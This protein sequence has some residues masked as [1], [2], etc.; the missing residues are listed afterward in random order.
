MIK[1]STLVAAVCA[2]GCASAS[3]SSALGGPESKL[4]TFA[5]GLDILPA[6]PRACPGE[7]IA[8]TYQVRIAGGSILPLTESD[9]AALIRHAVAAEPA[10]NGGWQMSTDVLASATS[11]FRLFVALGRDTTVRGDTVVVPT[12]GCRATLWE[13]GPGGPYSAR[14]AYV[15]LGKL[16]TPFYDSAVVAVFEAPGRGPAVSML[17]PADLHHGAIRINAAGTN[18][19]AGRQGHRGENGSECA[20]GED[21]GDG[22]PGQDGGPGGQV[23]IIVQ[24]GSEWLADLVSVS[25]AGGRGGAGGTGGAGGAA[26]APAR[27]SN[28]VCTPKAG[29]PGRSGSPGRD[30]EPG[31]RPQVKSVPLALLWPGSPIWSDSTARRALSELIQYTVKT[32]R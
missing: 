8:S 5:R 23:D 18:G 13:L 29:R 28:A 32:G 19:T 4:V 6:S 17:G 31:I 22:D 1:V 7:L 21:G 15:R 26:G 24:A 16:A 9:V 11:G 12:Y 2:L 20:D 25:N 14:N 27:G 10:R 30:G 3:G